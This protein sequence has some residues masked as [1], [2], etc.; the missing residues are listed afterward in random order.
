MNTPNQ[1]YLNNVSNE[2]NQRAIVLN[3]VYESQ[4]RSGPNGAKMDTQY[5]SLPLEQG[6]IIGAYVQHEDGKWGH[7]PVLRYVG[8]DNRFHDLRRDEQGQLPSVVL[9]RLENLGVDIPAFTDP[10]PRQKNRFVKGYVER[11]FFDPT[12]PGINKRAAGEALAQMPLYKKVTA[13]L[14]ELALKATAGV[15][16]IKQ[17]IFGDH[18]QK[19]VPKHH[20]Q[21]HR[22][23]HRP[24]FAS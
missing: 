10:V 24:R 18:T 8:D 3:E 15:A 12:V 19:H 2:L 13:G 5:G 16:G 1:V 11:S 23:S 17:H 6:Q 7:D 21:P 14:A 4:L 9:K 22:S 20:Y